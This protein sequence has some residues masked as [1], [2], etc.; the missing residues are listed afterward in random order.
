MNHVIKKNLTPLGNTHTKHMPNFK[1]NYLPCVT[2][3]SSMFRTRGMSV[4]LEIQEEQLINEVR[5]T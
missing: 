4:N 5:K 1:K 2:A 3:S